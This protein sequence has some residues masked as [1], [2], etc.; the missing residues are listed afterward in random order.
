M[1]KLNKNKSRNSFES[2][3][4][5]GLRAIATRVL[6]RVVPI[7]GIVE[8][9]AEIRI[10]GQGIC[11]QFQYFGFLKNG[12]ICIHTQAPEKLIKRSLD[13]LHSNVIYVKTSLRPPVC[14]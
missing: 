9:F 8:I 2:L 11:T 5:V 6:T 14:V 7:L 3:K 12:Y 1:E 13:K 4:N 10:N